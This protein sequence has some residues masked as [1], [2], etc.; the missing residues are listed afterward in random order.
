MQDLQISPDRLKKVIENFRNTSLIVVGDV[1]IDEYLW[2]D[3]KRISPEA[4][5]PVVEVESVSR[6]LGGAANVVQN[7][8]RLGIKPVLVSVCGNDE[9]GMYLKGSLEKIGCGSEGIIFSSA[10]PTTIKTRILARNQQVVRAD[11]ELV[12][13][14]SSDESGKLWESYQG[15]FDRC[16]G[17]IISDYGK[18]VI[19][20]PFLGQIIEKCSKSKHFVAIDPKERHFDLYKGVTVVTPNLRE[21]HAMLGVPYRNCSD[22]EIRDLGWKIVDNLSLPYLLITL[23]ERGMALFESSGRVFRH[24]PTMARK[25]FDVTGAGDTVISVF[26]AAV[27]SGATPIEAAFLANHAAGLTVAELGTAS[28][29]PVELMAACGIA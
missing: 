19:S 17:T 22:E 28:V 20:L 26:S 15:L 23:S 2:G 1:M 8:S 5:V 21:A 10:R 13:D 25:V 27:T 4:P 7:L 11:R 24:L 18:G 3:V 16:Q 29:S 12:K 14:L 6:G 9:N